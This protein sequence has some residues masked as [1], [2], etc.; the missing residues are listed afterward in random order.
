L[1]AEELEVLFGGAA[2]GGKSDALLMAALQWIDTPCYSAL[3]LRRTYSDLSLPGALMDRSQLWLRGTAAKWSDKDKTWRFPSRATL[4]FGF[5]EGPADKYRYQSS[6]FQFIGFDE[7]TQHEESSYLYLFSRLRRLAGHDVPLRMRAAS[8]PGGVGHQFVKQRFLIDG[9][10]AGRVF[11]PSKLEDNPH[12][13]RQEYT[14]SLM[15]LDP[16]TRAQLLHGDWSDY[17]GGFFKREWFPVLDSPPLG[18]T[19]KIRCWD[20]AATEPKKGK[21]PDWTV[22]VLMGKTKDG[23]YVV[24]DVQRTRA[25]PR[26]VE[27]L[28]KHCAEAD[29]RGVWIYM[30]QEPGS[31]GVSVID[32][33]TRNVLAGWRFRGVKT[34]G[35]KAE[36]AAPFSSQ[37]E[38]GNVRIV[39][40][41]WNRD[42]LDEVCG[43]PAGSHDDQVD[44]A[45]GAF[46]QLAI[47]KGWMPIWIDRPPEFD[48][49][50]GTSVWSRPVCP[51]CG[52]GQMV[53]RP[54]GEIGSSAH[55]YLCRFCHAVF[56]RPV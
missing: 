7:L 27:G 18:I 8:N 20:L 3:L 46:A 52:S 21:D 43:F 9:P 34:T 5:L 37:A 51:R 17:S 12:L 29:G 56:K 53:K 48:N 14:R 47:N 49:P 45:S 2:G 41:L 16:F 13:D 26:D 6:E 1:A 10:T 22:G 42:F 24:L 23:Q 35:N 32:N 36:R 19:R 11:I 25:T 38:S 15:Q 39:R 50:D 30:E 4:S 33:Y 55:P 54:E 40:A 31:A 28:V 44:A